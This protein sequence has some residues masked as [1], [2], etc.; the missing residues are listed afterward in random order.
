MALMFLAL[1]ALEDFS[2]TSKPILFLGEWC[3]KYERKAIWEKLNG[4]VLQSDKLSDAN[5]YEAYQHVLFTY[6]KLL[7]KLADWLNKFH[8]V[9]HSLAYW[10]LLVG[11]FL[12]W[13]MQV[14]YHRFLYLEA[15]F[16]KHPDLETYGL[17][18]DTFFTPSNTNEFL[19][20]ASYHDSWNLQIFTQLLDL[21][22]KK[23]IGYKKLS[24]ETEWSGRKAQFI[25]VSYKKRTKVFL[26]TIRLIN[27]LRRSQEVGILNGI[28]TVRD[29]FKLMLNS[30]FR[31]LPLLPTK[32]INRG[33]SLGLSCLSKNAI[34]LKKR[35]LLL[36]IPA[37]DLLST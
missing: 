16:L 7:P 31:I 15:A 17:S 10:K 28:F 30:R 27:R 25:D 19:C 21:Y 22:F 1:T 8:Q 12:F 2:D 18:Q 11:P 13:Y 32:P 9:N 33:Q 3:R 37:E 29:L 23:P 35:Q 4:S 34:D 5:S 24:W 6:E 20:L 36:N 26:N 14:V